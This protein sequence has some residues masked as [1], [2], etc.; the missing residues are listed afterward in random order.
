MRPV[1]WRCSAFWVFLVVVVGIGI[2]GS[3][4]AFTRDQTTA[5]ARTYK[6]Q[7]ARCHGNDGSGKDNQYEGLRAPEVIGQ[8][9]LPC[10]PRSFQVIRSAR[11]RTAKD[12][13]EYISAVMPVDQ[14]SILDADE[15][16]DLVAYLLEAN[17]WQPDDTPLDAKTA[18]QVVLHPDCKDS[19]GS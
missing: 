19:E 13:Y 9:A 10:E 6:R 18:A 16:W 3:A 17:G 2:V 7:C 4:Y 15:Y 5:G 12:V 14:P 8:G 11:F 1:I